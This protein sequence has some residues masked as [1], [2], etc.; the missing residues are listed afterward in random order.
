MGGSVATAIYTAILTN[1]LSSALP[2]NVYK[3]TSA[4]HL[5]SST[6]SAILKA[7]SMNT[8]AAY[9]ALLQLPGVTQILVADLEM[10][11]K[12]SYVQAFKMVYLIAL[13]FGGVAILCAGFT[14]SIPREKKTGQRVV[15]M[16]N[17]AQSG[18]GKVEQ[19]V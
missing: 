19:A 10:A 5:S 7:A 4:N 8:A 3:L 16:E 6:T 15:R 14:R 12:E 1:R 9:K 2:A 18:Q 17:E 13:A 11:V